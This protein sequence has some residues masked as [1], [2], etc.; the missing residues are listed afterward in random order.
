[1]PKLV[2]D[3]HPF[4]EHFHSANI[5]LIEKTDSFEAK[6]Q[7]RSA[8]RFTIHETVWIRR[9]SFSFDEPSVLPFLDIVGAYGVY[10]ILNTFADQIHCETEWPKA[11]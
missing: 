7:E 10:G 8:S 1:M 6:K 4:S 9:A 5:E 11:L 3:K 2:F